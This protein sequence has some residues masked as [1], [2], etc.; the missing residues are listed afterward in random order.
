MRFDIWLNWGWK[1]IVT[2]IHFT[3]SV[4]SWFVVLVTKNNNKV[5]VVVS[6]SEEIIQEF[7]AITIVKKIVDFL[8]GQGGGGR[9]DMAQGGAPLSN[10]IETLKDFVK[11]SVLVF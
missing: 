2:Y 6:V 5:S 9:K 7:D 8:G 11:N 4:F 3:K 10:K 1:E